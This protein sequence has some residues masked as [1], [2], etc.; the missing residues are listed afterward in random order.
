MVFE[1]GGSRLSRHAGIFCFV[2]EEARMVFKTCGL[3]AEPLTHSARGEP[4]QLW[5]DAIR[6]V[7][8]VA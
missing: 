4:W 2:M 3:A 5:R 8:R 7:F 1:R 6:W